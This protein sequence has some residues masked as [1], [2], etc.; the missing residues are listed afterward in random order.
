MTL[1]GD[2]WAPSADC[3]EL[4]VLALCSV[5]S[6]GPQQLRSLLQ[7]QGQSCLAWLHNL[8]DQAV[9]GKLTDLC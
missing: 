5:S 3:V 7:T 2:V 9:S 4:D 8:F 6:M 1:S